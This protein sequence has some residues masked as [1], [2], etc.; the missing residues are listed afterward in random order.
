MRIQIEVTRPR[1]LRLPRTWR[2]RA[3]LTL[4]V[5][6][7]VA[8]PVAW[9]A[10][11]F[12]DVPNTNPH[13]DDI[14]AIFGARITAGCNP[15]ANT[16]YCPDQAVR[17]DQMGSFLRRGLGRS[18]Q[19]TFHGEPILATDGTWTDLSTLNITAGGTTG[20]TGFVHLTGAFSGYI[21]DTTG[22]PCMARFRILRV[23][24]SQ[25]SLWFFASPPNA[26]PSG[27]FASA[28][29]GTNTW[30]VP[31][32]T[33]AVHQFKLQGQRAG[34]AGTVRG[35]GNLIGVYTPFGSTGGSTLGGE[36]GAPA[37]DVSGG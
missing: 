1:W 10:H 14:S 29:G 6:G 27:F 26:I 9:A 33:G 31:V 37:G 24:P 13:H 34:G 3:L 15:P 4:V 18:A 11:Q 2:T 28:D 7:A 8:V 5:A 22:C 23:S 20:G 17:R 25:E 12:T 32:P 21:T 36:G 35:Y 19:G 16:L 30:V